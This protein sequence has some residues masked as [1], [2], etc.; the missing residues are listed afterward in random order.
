[1]IIN[2][3]VSGDWFQFLVYQKENWHN[4]FGFFAQNLATFFN[5]VREAEFFVAVGTWLPTLMLFFFCLAELA[6]CMRRLP[7]AYILYGLVNL[8]ISYSP[9]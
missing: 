4:S 8:F 3:W 5:L 9:S 1:M 2:K 7:Q 6:L